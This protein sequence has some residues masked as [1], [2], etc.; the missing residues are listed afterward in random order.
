MADR[1]RI[2]I[3]DFDADDV[4]AFYDSQVFRVWHLAGKDRTYRIKSVQRITEEFR[5]ETTR[6]ALLWL[7]DSKGREVPLPLV[8][9]ATNRNT[10]IQLY[11]KRAKKDWPGKCVILFP[12]TTD[13]A[14]ETRDCIRVRN[15]VPGTRTRENKQGANVLPAAAEKPSSPPPS[16][17]APIDHDRARLNDDD[18]AKEGGEDDDDEI[19]E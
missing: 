17:P 1:T 16:S 3:E 15:Y 2:K 12:S 19:P 18:D 9:N 7:E 8:L 13:V 5:N 11:G 14:G 10:I 6:K 4:R